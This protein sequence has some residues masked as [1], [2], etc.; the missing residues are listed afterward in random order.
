M[1]S[2]LR[3]NKNRELV[4]YYPTNPE[5]IIVQNQFYPKGLTELDLYNY[6]MKNKNSILNQVKDREI[7]FF[8]GLETDD[9]I[10]KRKTPEGKF[11][12]LNNSNYNNLITGRTLSIHST[13]KKRENFGIV[14]I[15]SNH[16]RK[17]KIAA[18]EVYDYLKGNSE[19]KTLEIR[20]TGKDGFH[21]ICV[22]NNVRNIDD[23]RAFLKDTLHNKFSNQYEI[24]HYKKLGSKV[25]LDLSSN[26][27]RGGF[28]TLHSLSVLGLKCVAIPRS[29]INT[30]RKEDAKII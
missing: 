5:T 13:M 25:N 11:I 1:L 22:I 3:R 6:Y 4:E 18:I 17:S 28:I 23:I 14:D 15:D 29:K 9:P 21:I 8:L 19:V 16:F 10:V 27:Y 26:K 30:F 12:K 7:M 20:Y 24:A 2:L